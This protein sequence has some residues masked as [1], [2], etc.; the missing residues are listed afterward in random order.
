MG[1]REKSFGKSFSPEEK[2]D[3]QD[4]GFV[5]VVLIKDRGSKEQGHPALHAIYQFNPN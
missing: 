5:L 3:P 1:S 4:I 2:V